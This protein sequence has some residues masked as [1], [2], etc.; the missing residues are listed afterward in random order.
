MNFECEFAVF[1]L[2]LIT[3]FQERVKLLVAPV[4]ELLNIFFLEHKLCL[5]T[6]LLKIL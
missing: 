3:W 2:N 6:F 4:L 5:K 1:A